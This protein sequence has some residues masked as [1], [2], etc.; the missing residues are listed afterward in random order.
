MKL[1]KNRTIK[2]YF[3]KSRQ[4]SSLRAKL[5]KQ[6]RK[7]SQLENYSPIPLAERN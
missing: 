2:F 1:V 4:K 3:A 7:K 5:P 6:N